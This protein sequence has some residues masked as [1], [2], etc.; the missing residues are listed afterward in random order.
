MGFS[1]CREAVAL[2]ASRISTVNGVE[3]LKT[4]LIKAG[5]DGKRSVRLGEINASARHLDVTAQVNIAPLGSLSDPL[6]DMY[7]ALGQALVK[8]CVSGRTFV[9]QASDGESLNGYFQVEKLGFYI[10]DQY[11]F[12]GPQFLGI[13]TQDQILSRSELI[14][15][16]TA[17]SDPIF[18]I[19][20]RPFSAVT[21][22][23]FRKYREK[24]GMGGDFLLYSDVLWIES[25]QVIN[26][27]VL[28]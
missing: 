20:D 28:S 14:E 3:Q 25:D 22:G 9:R 1:R 27:G 26:L 13:W 11:D 21:N 7:G 24:I 12:N 2:A 23:D 19:G 8:V 16:A 18:D 15:A 17:G 10:R 6:D 4:L 5:W